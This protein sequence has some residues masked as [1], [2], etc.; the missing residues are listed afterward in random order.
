MKKFLLFILDWTWCLP[1][2]LIGFLMRTF[3]WRRKDKCVLE[4]EDF[5]PITYYCTYNSSLT[6][7]GFGVS[8][9]RYILFKMSKKIPW[10]R[11][12]ET[13][14][15]HEYGHK[16]QSRMLGPLYLP[17]VGLVSVTWN[18]L[19]RVNKKIHKKYYTRFPENWADKLGHVNRRPWDW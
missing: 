14:I 9:G 18:L 16:R 7:S 10:Y 15:R 2:T 3:F 11:V 13:T 6:S 4:T 1:Q 12:Q 17:V 8:M 5:G 19:S